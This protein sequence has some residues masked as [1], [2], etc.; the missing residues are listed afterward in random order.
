[1]FDRRVRENKADEEE[2]KFVVVS[3]G[4]YASEV[5]GVTAELGCF[6]RRVGQGIVRE[7][8]DEASTLAC[9]G[10]GQGTRHQGDGCLGRERECK[11]IIFSILNGYFFYPTVFLSLMAIFSILLRGSTQVHITTAI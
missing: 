2:A 8:E 11:Y 4:G 1:M 7:A 10:V 6:G 5:S 3:V 9:V